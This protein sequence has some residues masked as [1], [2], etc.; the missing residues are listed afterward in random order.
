MLVIYFKLHDQKPGG[1]FILG[2]SFYKLRRDK[3]LSKLLPLLQF[4]LYIVISQSHYSSP[5]ASNFKILIR[6]LDIFFYKII[7]FK[8]STGTAPDV[9]EKDSTDITF[10]KNP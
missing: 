10:L 7:F 5:S 4:T 9:A 1:S 2:L 8:K 6:I 3:H